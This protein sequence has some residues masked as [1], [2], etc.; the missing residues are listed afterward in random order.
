MGILEEKNIYSCW[1][2]RA[3][4]SEN[5]ITV[6][7][8]GPR[9]P[10]WVGFFKKTITAPLLA[11]LINQMKNFGKRVAAMNQR[12]ILKKYFGFK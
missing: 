6:Q 3:F 1:S 11:M 12:V 2:H 7:A 8:M 5:R 9:G 10:R 4:S